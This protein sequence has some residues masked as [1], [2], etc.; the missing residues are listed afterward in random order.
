MGNKNRRTTYMMKRKIISSSAGLILAGG[1]I[2]STLVTDDNAVNSESNESKQSKVEQS[3]PKIKKETMT[4]NTQPIAIEV[5]SQKQPL[6]TQVSLPQ[7]IEQKELTPIDF[8]QSAPVQVNESVEDTAFQVVLPQ[9]ES[10]LAQT[11]FI[12]SSAGPARKESEAADKI[13]E[14]FIEQDENPAQLTAVNEEL[15][16]KVQ[17]AEKA[18]ANASIAQADLEQAQLALENL[19]VQEEIVEDPPASVDTASV[20]AEINVLEGEISE[21]RLIAEEARVQ[22]VAAQSEAVAD[23]VIEEASEPVYEEQVI[24]DEATGEER[25]EMVEVLPENPE[26][27]IEAVSA[28]VELQV[29]ADQKAASAN[30]AEIDL[31]VK[32]SALIDVRARL[33]ESQ[34]QPAETEA[35]PVVSEEERLAAEQAVEQAAAKAQKEKAEAEKLVQEKA[36]AEARAAA[37]AEKAAQAKAQKEAEAAR[38]EK[39]AQVKKNNNQGNTIL[40]H[41][42]KYQ[43]VSYSWGGTTT[44]GMDCSGFTQKVYQDSGITIP[45]TTDAQKAAVNAVSSPQTGDL[46]FFSHDGGRTIGHVGIYSGNGQ[47]I[48]SQSSTGVAYTGVHSSY[49]G[50]RLVG[51]GRY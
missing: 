3:V 30:Q 47:F 50:P 27:S 44:A 41:A 13:E 14:E 23:V 43:G 9:E 12:I 2:L 40:D 34:S 20:Q 32:E 38:A 45:R 21:A 6:V 42:K 35:A 15:E 33:D 48:G 28:K 7:E 1:L 49:W 24:L 51:Y 5:E 37:E 8:A 29:A 36:E 19:S 25:I 10:P 39:A 11:D 4:L 18:Q 31:Q 46:V 17:T 16:N 26:A 22:A